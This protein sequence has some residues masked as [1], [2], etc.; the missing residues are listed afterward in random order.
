MRHA[1]CSNIQSAVCTGPQTQ[2]PDGQFA[3]KQTDPQQV[4]I[5]ITS[6]LAGEALS[7]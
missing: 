7:N 6:Q 4:R 1:L 5:T 2:R 3:L